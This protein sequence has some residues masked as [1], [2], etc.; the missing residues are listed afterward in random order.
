[1]RLDRT[2]PQLFLLLAVLALAQPAQADEPITVGD[3]TAASCTETALAN[4]LAIAGAVG[5]GTIN[6]QCGAAS[7]SIPV[8]A[9][10]MVPDNT[11]ICQCDC[12]DPRELFS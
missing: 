5:G 1:M 8:T 9:T 7:I 3:G 12:P 10:L 6:F 11:T 2:I 4:A